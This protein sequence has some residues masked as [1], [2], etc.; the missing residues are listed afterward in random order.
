MYFLDNN[1]DDD[2]RYVKMRVVVYLFRKKRILFFS[3]TVT[4]DDTSLAHDKL[5]PNRGYGIISL[6]Y[7]R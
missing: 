3:I 4:I 6:S 5:Y 2:K 1:D 7:R